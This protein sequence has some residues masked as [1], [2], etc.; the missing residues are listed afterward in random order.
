MKRENKTN[1]KTDLETKEQNQMIKDRS[2]KQRTDL[3]MKKSFSIAL[4]L[5]YDIF[6]I[7]L[8]SYTQT[9]YSYTHLL[10]TYTHT[11]CTSRHYFQFFMQSIVK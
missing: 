1:Q 5:K 4:F 10:Y 2:S 3:R 7:H 6:Y 9:F 11:Q 8:S